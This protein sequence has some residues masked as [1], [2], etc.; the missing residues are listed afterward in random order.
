MGEI[1]TILL[2]EKNYFLL[3]G[4]FDGR[5]L[6][7]FFD[8]QGNLGKI[9]K[10]YGE[11]GMDEIC[12][13]YLLGDFAVFGGEHGNL[14]FINTRQR[15]FMG[16]SFDLAPEYIYSIELCWIQNKSKAKALLMVSGESYNNNKKTDVLDVTLFFTKKMRNKK[17]KNILELSQ[18]ISK[19]NKIL[20]N[21]NSVNPIKLY[22]KKLNNLKKD[23]S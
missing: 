17:N 22:P 18:K 15:E 6:Q 5:V 9:M 16:L 4:D 12:F 19:T 21:Q 23:L 10:D 2:D 7:M 11:L 8:F 1:T 3:I 13:S 14:A 20:D